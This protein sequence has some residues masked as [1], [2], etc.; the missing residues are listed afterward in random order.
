MVVTSSVGGQKAWGKPE[1]R[2]KVAQQYPAI[3]TLQTK[4]DRYFK[5]PIR[6]GRVAHKSLVLRSLEQTNG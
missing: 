1:H 5:D 4:G 3:K 2:I 6:P